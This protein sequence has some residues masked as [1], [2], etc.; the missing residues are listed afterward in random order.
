MTP[1]I[2]RIAIAALATLMLTAS[3]AFAQ[4]QPEKRGLSDFGKTYSS[5]PAP[6]RLQG[7]HQ[8]TNVS[9]G[10]EMFRRVF[11]P[12]LFRVD[13]VSAAAP[14]AA[15]DSS[16]QIE[17]LQIGIGFAIGIVLALGLI[18]AVRLTRGRMLAHG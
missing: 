10:K 8:L 5:V 12:D 14:V 2:S 9:S 16:T 17:W 11:D 3:A 7:D 15:A 6:P 4:S 18:L 1:R 13:A